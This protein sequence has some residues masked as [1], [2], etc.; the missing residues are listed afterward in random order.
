VSIHRF[1]KMP[2]ALALLA[3][4]LGMISTAA[5][6]VPPVSQV[7]PT[8]GNVMPPPAYRSAFEGYQPYSDEKTVDWKQANDTA[9]QIGGW[10]AY[11]RESSQ[12]AS[13][14]DAARAAS[15]PAPAKP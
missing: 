8:A 9:G 6:P 12:D 15:S 2:V 13:P 5:Q 10:R 4:P 11:A 14:G 3:G 7:A 1:F